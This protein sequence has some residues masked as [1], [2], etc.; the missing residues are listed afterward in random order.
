MSFRTISRSKLE[1]F[2]NCPRCFY[3]DTVMEVK[4]PNSPPY[5]LNL[6]VDKLLK[7]EFDEYREKGL[8]HPEMVKRGLNSIPW[9]SPDLDIWRNSF[10]GIRHI[11][12]E[13]QIEL[14]GAVDD[15]WIDSE[16]QLQIVDYKATSRDTGIAI[17]SSHYDSYRR[18]L[19]IY[20]W[21]LSKEG[22][23]V[24]SV[25]Y[26]LF[27]NTKQGKNFQNRLNFEVKIFA[28]EQDFS[29]IAAE[30]KNIRKLWNK[31]ILPPF[32][33]KCE[34]CQYVKK[35]NDLGFGF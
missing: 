3:L 21:I 16:K 30:L 29:W 8:S 33:D 7:K 34:Y 20:Q 1:L 27:C 13:S 32:Q 10:R 5:S 31:S 23:R 6:A 18:Q 17:E 35:A 9:K 14:F 28:Q 4:R 12:Q 24:S 19:E 15:I 11:D 2:L 25:A 26:L 22:Y